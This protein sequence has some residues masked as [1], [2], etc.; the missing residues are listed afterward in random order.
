MC[1]MI[2]F[3]WWTIHVGNELHRLNELQFNDFSFI[4]IFNLYRHN[5][6]KTVKNGKEK[7]PQI[8]IYSISCCEL[9]SYVD[10]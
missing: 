6:A 3:N 4:I 2:D 7:V 5:G 9:S 1:C 8:N 10:A